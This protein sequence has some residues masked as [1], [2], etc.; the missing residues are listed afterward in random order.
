M[1]APPE[2]VLFLSDLQN[3]RID[4]RGVNALLAANKLIYPNMKRKVYK[5]LSFNILTE[6]N[7]EEIY[8][9]LLPIIGGDDMLGDVIGSFLEVAS[10]GAE[11]ALS[12][13]DGCL[14]VRIYD[15]GKYS[16]VYPIE[17]GEDAD[18]DAALL[19]LAEYT[20]REMVPFYLTDTPREELDRLSRLF[21]HVDARAYDDDDDVFVALVYSECDMLES[22]PTYSEGGI[23]LSEIT[24]EDGERYAAL[25]RSPEVNK[26]WGYDYR[27][28]APDADVGYF[29]DT[30]RVEFYSGIA[31]SLAVREGGLSDKLIGEGVIFDF[32][33]RGGAMIAVRLLP[34]YR[35][36]GIGKAAFR[37][38]IS[39]SREI[40]LRLVR[41]DVMCENLPSIKM[42]EACLERLPDDEGK[43]RF[44]LSL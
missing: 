17:L 43:A 15:D 13:S 8:A 23:T 1:S 29:L 27:E 36:R 42:C 20:V 10:E 19:S 24:D 44:E 2:P 32:N 12:G 28:D 14:L 35:G 40:G 3:L 41:A 22:P 37:A 31:I 21:L 38:L 16:F 30:V 4:I 11:V 33:Y 25:V 7:A 6:E 34:E 18:P 5:M 26:W 9:G 39:L